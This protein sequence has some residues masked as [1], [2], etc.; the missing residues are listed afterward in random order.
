MSIQKGSG[1]QK[2][3]HIIWI[4][5]GVVLLFIMIYVALQLPSLLGSLSNF[6]SFDIPD[7]GG[8]NIKKI[9]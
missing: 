5:V 1:T 8:I 7:F 6:G 3:F 4:I 2:A 9:L